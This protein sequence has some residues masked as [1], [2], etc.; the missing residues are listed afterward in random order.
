MAPDRGSTESSSPDA[1]LPLVS[2]CAIVV[3]RQY[4]IATH[5]MNVSP[6]TPAVLCS[7]PPHAPMGMTCTLAN[8]RAHVLMLVVTPH[9]L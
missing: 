6:S 2:N 1:T 9:A 3:A 7:Q 8:K 4:Y 5:D